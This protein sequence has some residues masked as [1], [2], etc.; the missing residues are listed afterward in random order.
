MGR[1]LVLIAQERLFVAPVKSTNA[2]SRRW[3]LFLYL[4]LSILLVPV[5]CDPSDFAGR[6]VLRHH[7]RVH[8]FRLHDDGAGASI[9]RE[10][11]LL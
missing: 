2:A 7:P 4:W 9:E 11:H 3:N 5:G 8:T 10:A 1:S 6:A